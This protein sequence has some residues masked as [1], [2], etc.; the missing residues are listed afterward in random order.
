[1][2]PEEQSQ[3]AYLQFAHLIIE[4][5]RHLTHQSSPAHVFSLRWSGQSLLR[6]KGG[7][8]SPPILE[9]QGRMRGVDE[10]LA[11]LSGPIH[12][13]V[14][15]LYNVYEHLCY[16]Q[17]LFCSLMSEHFYSCCTSQY[18]LRHGRSCPVEPIVVDHYSLSIW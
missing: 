13:Y 17:E 5:Q 12:G 10:E 6:V 11:P 7:K 14:L 2:S 1:M 16:E 18:L 4:R 3:R 9:R 8:S 15:G